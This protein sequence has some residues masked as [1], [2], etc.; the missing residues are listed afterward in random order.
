MSD[1]LPW[2]YYAAREQLERRTRLRRTVNGIPD[3][4]LTDVGRIAWAIA[5]AS[6]PD[7]PPEV[8]RSRL[9]QLG[10]HR[11]HLS[12][13]IVADDDSQLVIGVDERTRHVVERD[14]ELAFCSNR[15]ANG[16]ERACSYC[17]AHPL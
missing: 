7:A 17:Q 15:F 10:R 16:P 4:G 8:I 9:K 12:Q 11:V 3:A 6:D 5:H 2:T 13:A 14:L 1:Y